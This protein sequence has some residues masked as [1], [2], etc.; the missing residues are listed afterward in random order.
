MSKR[1]YCLTYLASYLCSVCYNDNDRGLIEK[2]YDKM[3]RYILQQPSI[4]QVW[5]VVLDEFNAFDTVSYTHLDV[6]KRQTGLNQ[7]RHAI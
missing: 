2:L 6:Y 3:V 1:K 7:M 4:K 5:L